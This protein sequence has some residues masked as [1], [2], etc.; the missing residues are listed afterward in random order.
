MNSIYWRWRAGTPTTNGLEMSCFA[1]RTK[2]WVEV[3]LLFANLLPRGLY[4]D[5]RD[6]GILR[7]LNLAR[8][9]N[10]VDGLE[11]LK[12][13][14][15]KYMNANNLPFRLQTAYFKRFCDIQFSHLHF[16]A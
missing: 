8:C 14:T 5:A 16:S 9:A 2:L 7:S 12:A 13:L 15:Y 3:Q 11:K 10:I 6:V 4:P 1:M